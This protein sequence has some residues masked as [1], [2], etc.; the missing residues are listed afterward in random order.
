MKRIIA[1]IVTFLI[2]LALF[3]YAGVDFL[4]RSEANAFIVFF[5]AVGAAFAAGYPGF[6]D[7]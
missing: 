4:V 7:K 5:A 3:W 1:A 6:D 2:V